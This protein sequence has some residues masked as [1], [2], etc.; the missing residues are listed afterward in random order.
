MEWKDARVKIQNFLTVGRH[1]DTFN[2]DD[3]LVI[4]I[5]Y[6]GFHIG[7]DDGHNI[8]LKW[9]ILEHCWKALD[10]RRT[11]DLN[12]YEGL[13]GQD[14]LNNPT[15]VHIVGQIFKKSGLANLYESTY[16]TYTG[17]LFLQL[18]LPF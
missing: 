2:H 8:N 18:T 5:N 14:N 12:I 15:Y 17:M 4:D 11:F 13:Y 6:D 1:L 3:F 10:E 7:A 16:H 9:H